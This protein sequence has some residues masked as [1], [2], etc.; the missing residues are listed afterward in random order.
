MNRREQR[1]WNME[2]TQSIWGPSSPS[3]SPERN[4][5]YEQSNEEK[6]KHSSEKRKQLFLI[7]YIINSVS[8]HH[9]HKCRGMN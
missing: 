4:D 3:T 1:R 8:H 2:C 7:Q 9:R 5:T 6:E